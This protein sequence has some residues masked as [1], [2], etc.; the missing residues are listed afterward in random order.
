M[1]LKK[2]MIDILCHVNLNFTKY[3]ISKAVKLLSLLILL[4]L[5]R[6]DRITKSYLILVIRF[7]V[8][9]I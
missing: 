6:K 9:K 1:K 5:K 2:G 8:W 4:I 3:A 7:F